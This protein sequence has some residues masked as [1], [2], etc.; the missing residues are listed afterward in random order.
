NQTESSASTTSS[1]IDIGS[2]HH[3][4]ATI[5]SSTHPYLVCNNGDKSPSHNTKLVSTTNLLRSPPIIQQHHIE[6]IC[7]NS[8]FGTRR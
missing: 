1:E 4:Y 3:R 6:G 2:S 5:G 7:G 8:S